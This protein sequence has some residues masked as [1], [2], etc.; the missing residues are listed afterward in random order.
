MSREISLELVAYSRIAPTDSCRMATGYIDPSWFDPRP[1][2]GE[3]GY[4]Y[5]SPAT[6]MLA[7]ATVAL[8]R[9][10]PEP[11]QREHWGVVVGT[12]FGNFDV[13]AEFA[14]TIANSGADAL[15]PMAA[16]NFSVNVAASQLAIRHGLR[17][18]NIT[19]TQDIRAGADALLEGMLAVAAG[20][21]AAVIAGAVE[22]T[23]PGPVL[24]SSASAPPEIAD[25]LGAGLF[26]L[27]SSPDG[28]KAGV[29]L[30]RCRRTG[31]V[32][33]SGFEPRLLEPLLQDMPI[34]DRVVLCAPP[35]VI[36][37]LA[38]VAGCLRRRWPDITIQL[39]PA[40]S[41][42]TA[43][44]ELGRMHGI[45]GCHLLLCLDH[46]RAATGLLLAV[47]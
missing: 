45:T 42:L 26:L 18:F 22:P 40:Y 31:P 35:P 5:H 29:R 19:L 3:R 7:A 36:S 27:K 12:N 41:S 15:P 20:R 43:V 4:K 39:L 33:D 28:S 23:I 44:T 21:A 32:D 10:L 9:K 30:L 1:Y 47:D 13:L 8:E 34:P 2:L 25:H 17:A 38:G 6:R 37:N 14:A 11:A 46:Y 24:L 16:P